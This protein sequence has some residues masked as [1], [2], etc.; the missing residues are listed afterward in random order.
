MDEIEELLESLNF[1]G[2]CTREN[3]LW[4]IQTNKGTFAWIWKSPFAD[5]I[6]ADRLN[7]QI[8]WI[9]GKPASGKSTLMHHIS[10]SKELPG[11]L[12]EAMEPG[13]MVLYHFFDFRAGKSTRNNLEGL[14]RSLLYQLLSQDEC[15]QLGKSQERSASPWSV[16]ELRDTLLTNLKQTSNPKFILLDGLDEFEDNQQRRWDLVDLLRQMSRRRVKVCIASRPEPVF[17]AAFHDLPNLKMQDYNQ[18]GI[19]HYVNST[20]RRSLS[21]SEFFGNKDLVTISESIGQRAEGVFLWAHFATL[22]LAQGFAEGHSL[23]LLQQRLEMVPLE[24]EEIYSEIFKRLDPKQREDAG[25][26]LRLVCFARRTLTME[27]LLAAM[28]TIQ[29]NFV[30]QTIRASSALCQQLERRILATTGGLLQT[31]RAVVH[32]PN[33]HTEESRQWR[34]DTQR[35]MDLVAIVHRTVR[36]Y[37]DSGGW[38]KVLQGPHKGSLHSEVLWLKVCAGESASNNVKTRHDQL[39][40]IGNF[41]RTEHTYTACR[42]DNS[43]KPSPDMGRNGAPLREYA[44]LYM[45]HH[46]NKV[47]QCVGLSSISFIYTSLTSSFVRLHRALSFR[48]MLADSNK[49]Y[50]NCHR[51]MTLCPREPLHVA[52]AHGLCL[53]VSDYLS[54]RRY[55]GVPSTRGHR[56]PLWWSDFPQ[57]P[58]RSNDFLPGLVENGEEVSLLEYAV[59]HTY[60]SDDLVHEP[61]EP[62]ENNGV[63]IAILKYWPHVDDGAMLVA[64]Q[65]ASLEIVRLL[66]SYRPDGKMSFSLKQSFDPGG[67]SQ[68]R[69]RKLFL[70]THWDFYSNEKGT[71]DLLDLLPGA[72]EQDCFG[73]LHF[74]CRRFIFDVKDTAETAELCDV[75]IVRG[76]C[77]NDP[78]GP[79]GTALHVSIMCCRNTALS[80]ALIER[81]ADLNAA[82]PLGTPLG[83][84]WLLFNKQQPDTNVMIQSWKAKIELLIEMGAVNN[85]R[86]P[87]GCIPSREWML[88]TCNAY[89]SLGLSD[90]PGVFERCQELYAGAGPYFE[91]PLRQISSNHELPDVSDSSDELS[92]TSESSDMGVRTSSED[93][94][95]SD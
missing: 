2:R 94:Q 8:F 57:L 59:G 45:L 41:I 54:E 79:F 23:L 83:L 11:I 90:D 72:P 28:E 67:S 69:M 64:L 51:R 6:R 49:G 85:M 74:V 15:H 16:G 82:G 26:M 84:A 40:E 77:I 19:E 7:D 46:A 71:E 36:T 34:E 14:L 53:F 13:W 68:G 65:W 9:C 1:E 63:L 21:K 27:E 58:E 44:A 60:H 47:E 70:S 66:L 43:E 86:D 93:F 32:Y 76:V 80:K 12:R 42:A 75:L 18:E 4:A 3:H 10:K 56:Y 62:P 95:E 52:V 92:D 17:S 39:Q 30:A 48:L 88:H 31:F 91:P 81:G 22:E 73:P 20:L 87:N 89:G 24:L 35:E 25:H 37:L 5:W 29:A 61:E 33:Y 78:C 55:A 50:C 38:F